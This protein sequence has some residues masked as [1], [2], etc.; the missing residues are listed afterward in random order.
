MDDHHIRYSRVLAHLCNN[1]YSAEDIINAI[2]TS[3]ACKVNQ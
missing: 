1:N 3:P 2:R